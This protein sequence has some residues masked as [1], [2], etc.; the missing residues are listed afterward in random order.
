M[1]A[2]GGF[3]YFYPVYPPQG[4]G[5]GM[6][7]PPP[8]APHG[9]YAPPWPGPISGDGMMPAFVAGGA[10]TGLFYGP[11]PPG[12]D[13]SIYG[14]HPALMAMPDAGMPGGGMPEDNPEPISANTWKNA[15]EPQSSESRTTTEGSQGN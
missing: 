10:A 9:P 7:P 2:T 15:S 4:R 5:A 1:M 8:P 14:M 11:I 3:A 13:M 6:I 12:M